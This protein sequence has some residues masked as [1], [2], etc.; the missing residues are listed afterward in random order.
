MGLDMKMGNKIFLLMVFI[1]ILLTVYTTVVPEAQSAGGDLTDAGMCNATG[2]AYNI[3][4]S[5]CENSTVNGSLCTA[6]NQSVPLG[7]MFAS[8]G[9]IFLIIMAVMFFSI[10]AYIRKTM[11]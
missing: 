7:S 8:N 4:S 6:P 2:C 1:V 5:A 9:V 3:T 11:F 10:Y